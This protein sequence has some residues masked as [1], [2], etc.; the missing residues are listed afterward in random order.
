MPPVGADNNLP[1]LMALQ[2]ARHCFKPMKLRYI[3]IND[4]AVEIVGGTPPDDQL[5]DAEKA[6]EA[7]HKLNGTCFHN[8]TWCWRKDEDDM[9]CTKCKQRTKNFQEWKCLG[10]KLRPLDRDETRAIPI[11]AVRQE[12]GLCGLHVCEK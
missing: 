5:R 3:M 10:Y 4:A 12:V 11:F 2:I 1:A 7:S 8:W 9:F 6:E